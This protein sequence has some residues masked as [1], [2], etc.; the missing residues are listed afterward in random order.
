MS[1][2]RE[3]PPRKME[4][5]S[6]RIDMRESESVIESSTTWRMESELTAGISRKKKALA[7]I[8]LKTRSRNIP[9][10]VI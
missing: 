6:M 1:F 7:A 4:R 5:S 10:N 9:L 8:P 3:L 2:Q